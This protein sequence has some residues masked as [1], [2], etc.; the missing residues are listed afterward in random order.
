MVV[1]HSNE[2]EKCLRSSDDSVIRSPLIVFAFL[3][4]SIL[5]SLVV[6]RMCSTDFI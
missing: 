2:A 6:I 5:S 1:I 4:A 3:R